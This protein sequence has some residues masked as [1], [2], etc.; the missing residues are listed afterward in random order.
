MKVKKVENYDAGYSR[1]DLLKKGALILAATSLICGG[2]ASCDEQLA[3]DVVCYPDEYDG[4]QVCVSDSDVSSEEISDLL[5]GSVVCVN[6][7]SDN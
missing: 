7:S 6:E 3:G 5:C 4:G 2:A 1:A